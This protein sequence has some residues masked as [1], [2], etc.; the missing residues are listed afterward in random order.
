MNRVDVLA[1]IRSRANRTDRN[2][3]SVVDETLLEA[4]DAVAELIEAAQAA[5]DRSLKL[6]PRA[7]PDRA[8]KAGVD[9]LT[10]EARAVFNRVEAALARVGGAA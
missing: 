7:N 2:G 1:V 10:D 9:A 3:L 6:N 5:I 8:G 4:A